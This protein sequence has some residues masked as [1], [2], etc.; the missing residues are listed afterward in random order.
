MK[1]RRIYNIVINDVVYATSS[2]YQQILKMFDDIRKTE[3]KAYIETY[4]A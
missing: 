4:Y 1:L 3:P 2:S